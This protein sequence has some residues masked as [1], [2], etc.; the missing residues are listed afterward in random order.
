MIT[1]KSDTESFAEKLKHLIKFSEKVDIRQ[2]LEAEQYF[3]RN[4]EE[5]EVLVESILQREREEWMYLADI[6]SEN[7]D[8]EVDVSVNME[9]L[10]YLL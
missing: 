4:G 8:K 1:S 10:L 6:F 3:K 9:Y 2:L 7:T 5:V